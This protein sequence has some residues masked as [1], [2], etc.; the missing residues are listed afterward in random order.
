MKLSERLDKLA[1]LQQ[2]ESPFMF[3]RFFGRL[4]LFGDQIGLED[5]SGRD[6][7]TKDEFKLAV[8]WLVEELG[9]KIIWE[10]SKKEKK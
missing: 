8:C 6:F 3:S 2:V 9:G 5:A 1:E 10:K 4:V 7:G